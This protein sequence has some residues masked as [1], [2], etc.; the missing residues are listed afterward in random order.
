[1]VS[2]IRIPGPVDGIDL[3]R[4]VARRYPALPVLLITGFGS[5]R[6]ETADFVVLRKPVRLRVLADAI[7]TVVA[8]Q[9]SSSGAAGE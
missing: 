1:M 8:A 4:T 5:T 6:R 3:A 9:N 7:H 2:D